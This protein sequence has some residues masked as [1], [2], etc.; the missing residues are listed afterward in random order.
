MLARLPALAALVASAH[1]WLPNEGPGARI[2]SRSLELFNVTETDL[3]ASEHLG[4]NDRRWTPSRVPI[5]GVNLGSLF[6]YEPWLAEPEWKNANQMNCGDSKS[7]F[8]CVIK[9][10]QSTAN[11]KFQQ[12][13]QNFIPESDFDLM[14]AAG[15]NTVRI[16]V[17]YWMYEAIIDQSERFP[18]GGL[19]HLKRICGYASDR[20]FYIWLELHGAPGAQK[21]Q[22]PFTGQ[23]APTAGFYNNYNYGRATQFLSW[24]TEVVH[25]TSRGSDNRMRNVGTLAVLNEPLA[26]E[27]QVD[28]LRSQFYPKAYTAIRDKERQ[29]SIPANDALHVGFMN[30]LWGSGDPKQFLPS[31]HFNTIFEDHRYVKYDTSVP[32]LHNDYIRDACT[33]DRSSAGEDPTVVT[34]W[35]ISPPDE[36]TS[37]WD[38]SDANKAF[39]EQWFRAFVIGFERSTLGWTFWTW[40]YQSD[41]WRWSYKGALEAGVI[42]RD[43]NSIASSGACNGFI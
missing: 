31:G 28:S 20:G 19:E 21:A 3:D 24:M 43:L 41:D 22:E 33:N 32:K 9:L 1:A 12:H 29:L 36:N 37:Y 16:P 17:G 27:N 38:R 2:S 40:K 42:P 11:Q 8:D 35:S 23:Y 6:V 13:W 18:R 26:W 25:K 34:E 4:S 39:F 5:R 10:G 30:T 14:V 15:I 7:E